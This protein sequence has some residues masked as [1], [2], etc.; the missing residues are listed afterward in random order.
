MK[1]WSENQRRWRRRQKPN[2]AHQSFPVLFQFYAKFNAHAMFRTVGR[3]E[4]NEAT[5]IALCL[6][7]RS[8]RMAAVMSRWWTTYR[9]NT[10]RYAQKSTVTV[11]RQVLEKWT[12][13]GHF[14]IRPRVC[15]SGVYISVRFSDGAVSQY[16]RNI[17]AGR[18]EPYFRCFKYPCCPHF[19]KAV[20]TLVYNSSVNH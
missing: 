18:L 9:S 20:T 4:Y 13:S 12:H 19:E 1:N 5:D 16:L 2:S 6:R 3:H 17:R 11:W 15:I 10:T 14:L 8:D 7:R